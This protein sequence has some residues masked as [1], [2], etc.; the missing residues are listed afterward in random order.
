[1]ELEEEEEG[2]QLVLGPSSSEEEMEHEL[3]EEGS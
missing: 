2:S 3:E 1:M